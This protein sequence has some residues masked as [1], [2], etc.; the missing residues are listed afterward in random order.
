MS[1]THTT[2]DLSFSIVPPE[3]IEGIWPKIKD[4]VKR[5]NDTVLNDTDI[6][7]YLKSGEYSLWLI[8]D[9]KTEEI[10]I[11]STLAILQYPR[12]LVCRVVTLAG[13][14]LEEWLL[15]YLS[16]IEDWARSND[17]SYIEVEGRKGWVKTLKE[18]KVDYYTL[19]KKL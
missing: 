10:I 8:T 9:N 18:Y 19:R 16:T 17:C 5:T 13:S 6:Y 11:V 1:N 12:D 4:Q 3:D 14:R 7:N 15:D 2:E